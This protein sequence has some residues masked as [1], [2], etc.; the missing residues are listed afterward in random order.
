MQISDPKVFDYIGLIGKTPMQ[1]DAP[2]AKAAWRQLRDWMVHGNPKNEIPRYRE[3]QFQPGGFKRGYFGR[4]PWQ[5]TMLDNLPKPRWLKANWPKGAG[6]IAYNPYESDCDGPF[7]FLRNHAIQLDYSDLEKRFK[8]FEEGIEKTRESMRLN[9]RMPI[10][11]F[12]D[13]ML[14]GGLAPGQWCNIQARPWHAQPHQMAMLRRLQELG[15]PI[16]VSLEDSEAQPDWEA[17]I[18][19]LN[20]HVFDSISVTPKKSTGMR[21][22][23]TKMRPSAGSDYHFAFDI[24]SRM[25]MSSGPHLMVWDE[26]HIFPYNPDDHLTKLYVKEREKKYDHKAAVNRVMKNNKWHDKKGTARRLEYIGA[27]YEKELKAKKK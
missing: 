10:L 3:L 23:R 21:V 6:K 11:G 22:V 16:V 18:K 2:E 1:L 5:V 7:S 26:A 12:R 14:G 25:D 8:E 13:S 15:K 19:K 9:P 17:L 20:L 27:S 24:E 4:K